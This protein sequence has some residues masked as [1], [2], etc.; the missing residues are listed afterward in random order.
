METF[1]WQQR[2]YSWRWFLSSDPELCHV[3]SGDL[4]SYIPCLLAASVSCPTLVSGTCYSWS[5]LCHY[6]GSDISTLANH[7]ECSCIFLG[8]GHPGVHDIATCN[9]YR[10]KNFSP[11][12]DVRLLVQLRPTLSGEFFQGWRLTKPSAIFGKLLVRAINPTK[13]KKV[14]KWLFW[15]LYYLYRS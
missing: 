14:S 15:W 13:A 7:M 5:C 4:H 8:Y 9:S 10:A 11:E 6:S 2:L 12:L 3:Y 1:V